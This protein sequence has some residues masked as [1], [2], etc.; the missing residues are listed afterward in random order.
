MKNYTKIM[1]GFWLLVAIVT[2]LIAFK[3]IWQDGLI[4]GTIMFFFP[5]VISFGMWYVRRRYRKKVED[6]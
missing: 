4:E 3:M 6:K 5:P 1:E 2:S